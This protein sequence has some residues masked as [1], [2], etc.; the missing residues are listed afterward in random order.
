MTTL[1]SLDASGAIIPL[2]PGNPVTT[3]AG[4]NTVSYAW[5]TLW[6]MADADLLPLNIYRVADPVQQP[7]NNQVVCGITYERFANTIVATSMYQTVAPSPSVSLNVYTD[8]VHYNVLYKGITVNVAEAN[9]TP[10]EILCDGTSSTQASLSLLAL[11]GQNY[12]TQSKTWIDNNGVATSILG[13]ECITL[14]TEVG[15]WI[16]NT[17]ITYGTVLNGISNNSITT[18]AEIDAVVWPVS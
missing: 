8:L 11:F 17:Y 10:K 16:S 15:N 18:T 1:V 6:A 2:A 12:P 7:A 14:A 13:S 5:S 3:G 9:S 4:A